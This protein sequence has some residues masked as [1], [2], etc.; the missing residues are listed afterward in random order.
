MFGMRSMF[1]LLS[2]PRDGK[3]LV[4]ANFTDFITRS[5]VAGAIKTNKVRSYPCYSLI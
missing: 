1:S 5:F 4:G 3:I 2:S